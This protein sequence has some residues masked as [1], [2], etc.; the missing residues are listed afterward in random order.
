MDWLQFLSAL[1]SALAWPAAVVTVVCLLKGPIL[2][3]IPKIRAVKYGELHIDL[4]EQLQAIQDALPAP[5]SESQ[6]QTASQ[7]DQQPSQQP[8]QPAALQLKT[9]P[10]AMSIPLQIAAISPRGAMM[11]AWLEVEAALNAALERAGLHRSSLVRENMDLLL[12][13]GLVNA[14]TYRALKRT[15]VLRVEALH[16]HEREIPYEDA[17]S[18]AD[19]CSRLVERLNSIQPMR[20]K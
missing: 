17:L 11:A 7:P 14:P 5:S 16:M 13:T 9:A 12:S 8:E 19:V 10:P 20:V 6:Q 1:V 3:L 4:T 15:Y 18:M 2:G